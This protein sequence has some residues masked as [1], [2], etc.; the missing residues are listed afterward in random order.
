M[1]N[2]AG[3]FKLLNFEPSEKRGNEE[4]NYRY[5]VYYQKLNIRNN[6]LLTNEDT[7]EY[8]YTL[9][10]FP[11]SLSC[12]SADLNH[13][14][15][16]DMIFEICKKTGIIQIKN[17]PLLEYIYLTPHNLHSGKIWNNLFDMVV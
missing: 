16:L 11:V 8:L 6:N 13:N 1:Q 14:K 2:I 15:K 5:N 17:T 3:D 10:D 4:I 9:H 7:M 12:V